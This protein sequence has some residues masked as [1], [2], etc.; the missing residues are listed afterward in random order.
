MSGPDKW[1]SYE[2]QIDRMGGNIM[3]LPTSWHVLLGEGS[4]QL[5]ISDKVIDI[6]NISAD[7]DI[8]R[9]TEFNTSDARM[10]VRKPYPDNLV[11]KEFVLIR[12]GSKTVYSGKI[13]SIHKDLKI[14]QA[15]VIISDISQDMRD[16]QLDNFGISKRVRLS[17]VDDTESGEYPF[18]NNL[19]PVSDKSLINPRS[20]TIPLTLVDHFLTEGKLEP[21]NI[22][23]DED[24]LRSEGEALNNDPD[25][26]I[27]AP[28]RNKTI[29]YIISK[30]LEFYEIDNSYV[31]ID[32]LNTEEDY[33][34]TYGRVGYDLES[35]LD[36]NVPLAQGADTALFWT[37][38]VT[39][40]LVDDNKF[41]FLYSSRTGLPSIIEYN[42]L[43]DTYREVYK[44]DK[45]DKHA[46]WWKFVKS[47]NTFY[48]L[49]TTISSVD[50]ENPTLGAYDPTEPSPGT[51]IEMLSGT[52]LSTYIE[53]GYAFRPVV[54]MYYQFGFSPDGFNNNVRQGIQP[55]TRKSFILHNSNL[56]YIYAGNTT[57][58]IAKAT[59]QNTA[60]A[61]VQ[62]AQ[63]GL[64]N[65]LGLDF[66]I[67]G[68]TLYGAAIF[69]RGNK[70]SRI[71]YKK[72]L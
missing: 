60:T 14:H 40:F 58:G 6:S 35:N 31:S 69:Q 16:K 8:E 19:S 46:E 47:G 28:Y 37:G 4:S 38:S 20:E 57:C 26:T 17:K 44:R 56:Y 67:L 71:V 22:S 18:T 51:F 68:N 11:N 42:P 66:T 1:V 65:H 64:F 27:K 59:A 15:D 61:F 25:V 7:L 50:V 3:P 49:G 32:L 36:V 39:D 63:D 2:K 12:A 9:P 10:F 29:L 5:D 21:T 72:D 52:T 48:I 34:S 53:S 13:L 45:I 24:T 70:G 62:V 41:Y 54:G 23:Y 33:F 55:D 43:T 30:I